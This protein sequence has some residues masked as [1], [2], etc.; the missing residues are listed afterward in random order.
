MP[1]SFFPQIEIIY[2]LSFSSLGVQYFQ[3]CIIFK[4]EFEMKN[5]KLHHY[6]SQEQSDQIPNK[7]ESLLNFVFDLF[8]ISYCLVKLVC[9]ICVSDVKCNN[10]YQTHRSVEK[11]LKKMPSIIIPYTRAQPWTMMVH[12]Q[13]T[14]LTFW[15]MM[16]ALW[17]KYV[18][19]KTVFLFSIFGLGHVK[20][21]KNLWTSRFY[22][23]SRNQCPY[24][25]EHQYMN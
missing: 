6:K 3:R 4:N 13:N 12:T 20:S 16:T 7:K 19:N 21:P 23:D 15:A 2:G 5:R 22:H 18:A 11:S 17:F 24:Q 8:W 25:H 1:I 9:L 10:H 14:S